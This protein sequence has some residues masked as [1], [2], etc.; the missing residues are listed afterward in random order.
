MDDSKRRL[1]LL[2]A[3]LLLVTVPLYAPAFH[4]TGPRYEY[5]S[6]EITTPNDTLS[7]ADDGQ[8][9]EIAG[10]DCLRE[11]EISRRCV[12]EA[13]ALNSTVR[14]DHPAIVR[15]I[16]GAHVYSKEQYVAFNANHPL[17]RRTSDWKNGSY[18]LGLE[19]VS[20]TTVLEDVA[21]DGKHVSRQTRTAVEEGSVKTRK[22]L[23]H[24]NRIVDTPDGYFVVYQ[25]ERHPS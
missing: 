16:G 2:I 24:A 10:I 1:S 22:K 21:I 14:A 5:K 20:A 9:D 19:R 6:A 8:L 17:Y 4:I 18:A 23:P 15:V 11:H 3:G 13:R 25:S 7:I 12:Y